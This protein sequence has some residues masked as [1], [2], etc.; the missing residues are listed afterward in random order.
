MEKD[1]EVLHKIRQ[2]QVFEQLTA[3]LGTIEH[4]L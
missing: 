4:E 1:I 2:S 3:L